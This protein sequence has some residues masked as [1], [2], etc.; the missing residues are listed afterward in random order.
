MNGPGQAFEIDYTSTIKALMGEEA[1]KKAQSKMNST[2]RRWVVYYRVTEKFLIL[3]NIIRIRN[4]LCES[5]SWEIYPLDQL[6]LTG[7]DGNHL[8]PLGWIFLLLSHHVKHQKSD[9]E[10]TFI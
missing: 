10:S 5:T 3:N 7:I 6:W 9:D 8:I 4:R 1:Y 2:N